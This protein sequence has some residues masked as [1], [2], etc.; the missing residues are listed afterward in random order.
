MAIYAFGSKGLVDQST[1]A[2]FDARY[3]D[4]IL[5]ADNVYLD[6]T[7]LL[8]RRPPLVPKGFQFSPGEILDS[9]STSDHYVI[10]RR[11]DPSHTKHKIY[12]L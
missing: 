9:K 1:T 6:R 3:N 4:K 7:N 5:E 10:V 2:I 8:A 12:Y 11:V